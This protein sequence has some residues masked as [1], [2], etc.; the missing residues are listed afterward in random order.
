MHVSDGLLPPV[1]WGAGYV[2][3]AALTVL[4]LRGL[5]DREVPRLALLTS[6]F[7]TASL[8]HVRLGGASVHL[9]LPGVIGMVAGRR[10]AIPVLIGVVLQSVLFAHGGLT[11]IG[12]NTL[13]MGLPAVLAGAVVRGWSARALP[14]RADRAGADDARQRRPVAGASVVGFCAGAGA[15]LLALLLFLAFG[16]TADAVFFAAIGVFVVAHLPL[17]VVEGVVAAATLNYLVQVKPEVLYDASKHLAAGAPAAAVAGGG[18][19]DP[20]AQRRCP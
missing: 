16:L 20:G 2:G 7:F 3:A 6:V 19:G 5:S 12:V 1:V 17:A 14:G 8:L 18:A 15:V 4:S 10:A 13:I 11:T 9:L